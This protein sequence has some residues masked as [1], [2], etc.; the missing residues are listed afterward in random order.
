MFIL[1]VRKK[2]EQYVEVMRNFFTTF[3]NF[4]GIKHTHT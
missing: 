1:E 3:H 2:I 4:T